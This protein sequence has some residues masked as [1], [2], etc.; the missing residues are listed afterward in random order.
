[1][2]DCTILELYNFCI[3]TFTRKKWQVRNYGHHSNSL[4]Y[5]FISRPKSISSH[6]LHKIAKNFHRR[7]DQENTKVL[8]VFDES[9]GNAQAVSSPPYT[10]QVESMPII[11]SESNEPLVHR[12][13]AHSVGNSSSYQD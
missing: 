2:D 4:T 5:L 7:G 10:S 13:R 1:M 9:D 11:D 8:H 6:V 12:M 3:I